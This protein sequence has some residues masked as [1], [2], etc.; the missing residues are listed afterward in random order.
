MNEPITLTTLVENSVQVRGLRAEHGLAFHLQCSG[1]SLL[2]DTGQSDL[3]IANADALGVALARLDAIVLSHGHYDHTGGLSNVRACAPKARLF[4]HPE[5]VK[6]KFSANA[7]SPAQPAGMTEPALQA[8]RH[9]GASVTW[10]RGWTEVLPGVF[11]TGEI[12]RETSFEDTGGRFFRDA[13]ATQPDPLTDDQALVCDTPEG[14][15]VVLGCA[16]A[17]VVNTLRHIR[18]QTNGQR[19]HTLIGGLHL[20]TA[21]ATRMHATVQALRELAVAQLIPAHC[22]GFAAATRLWAEFPGR[23]RPSGVGTRL[24]FNGKPSP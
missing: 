10:T 11:A 1:H 18:R 17:G 6:P 15:M 14:L 19:I 22:T 24:I 4:L 2:F 5:A 8:V 7:A 3:L 16:H 21:E 12:P 23:C 20:L 9:A 13:S